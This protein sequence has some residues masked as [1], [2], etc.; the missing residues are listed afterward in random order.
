MYELPGMFWRMRGSFP[1]IV[2]GVDVQKGQELVVGKLL[3]GSSRIY[4]EPRVEAK[5]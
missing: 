4:G 3:W 1:V 2:C 5:V